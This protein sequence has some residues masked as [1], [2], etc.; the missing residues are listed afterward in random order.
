MIKIYKRKGIPD[1]MELIDINDQ[2]FNKY[3][4]DKLDENASE[5]IEKIDKSKMID[6]YSISS[7]FDGTKLNIDKL[8]TGCKTVL[9]IMYNNEKVFN[10]AECGENALSVIYALK[11]GNIFC[12]YPMIA[13]DMKNV[14][15]ID[16][17]GTH[18][19]SDYEELKA[20]WK[21]EN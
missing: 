1:S 6:K 7:R 19:F 2:Y 9:N 10:V 15:A 3:T 16:S 5:I 13:F 18:V 4:A 11:H 12:D 8:S 21:N 17:K 20:W 14:E